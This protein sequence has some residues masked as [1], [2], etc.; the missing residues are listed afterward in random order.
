M[1]LVPSEIII[2]VHPM[3]KLQNPNTRSNGNNNN[4]EEESHR[5]EQEHSAHLL[6]GHI[7]MVEE[8]GEKKTSKETNADD[9]ESVCLCGWV[10]VRKWDGGRGAGD[11]LG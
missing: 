9:R 6:Q 7:A 2:R 3:N 1:L 10:G 4:S 8:M 11:K 5:K